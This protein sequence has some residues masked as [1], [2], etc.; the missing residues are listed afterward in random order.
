MFV[1]PRRWRG[2]IEERGRPRSTRSL[3]VPGGPVAHSARR[4]TLPPDVRRELLPP[5][6]CHVWAVP[7]A[8]ALAAGEAPYLGWLSPEERARLD[9]FRFPRDRRQH[10]VSRALMRAA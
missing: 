3:P 2:G 5:H 8:D 10:L 9:R 6:E 7:V 4:A 1:L